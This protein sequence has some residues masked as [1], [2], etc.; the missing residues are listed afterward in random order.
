MMILRKGKTMGTKIEHLNANLASSGKYPVRP[1][2]VGGKVAEGY[3]ICENGNLWSTKRYYYLR[4]LATAV[5]GK[6]KY[7]KVSLS[8]NGKMI[9]K[10]L[11][12]IVCE[13]YHKFPVP[14][15]YGVTKEEW[16]QTPDS[17][18][19]LLKDSFEVNHIDHEHTN[20]HPSN[21]EWVTTKQ[22]SKCYQ[23]HR[24]MQGK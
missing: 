8:I 12:R 5:S 22:N 21:L 13:T 3:F 24:R 15:A 6:S 11:H 4:K 10:E 14:Y 19:A 2:I 20:Y 16:E 18:K 1:A 9:T 17:V 23:E 7:P